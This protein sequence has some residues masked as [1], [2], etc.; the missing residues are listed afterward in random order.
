MN[1]IYGRQTG[2]WGNR[3]KW[4]IFCGQAVSTMGKCTLYDFGCSKISQLAF[5]TFHQLVLTRH[6]MH[7]NFN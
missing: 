1:I 3:P 6:L 2:L 7:Q 4:E 5:M